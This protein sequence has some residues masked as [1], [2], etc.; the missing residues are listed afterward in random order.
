VLAVFDIKWIESDEL[1][2]ADEEELA[3]FLAASCERVV[4]AAMTAR[5]QLRDEERSR[6]L[7][8]TTRDELREA[9]NRLPTQ[10][11]Q[12]EAVQAALL[13]Y[14]TGREVP[15]GELD[16]AGLSA[17]LQV[18]RWTGESSEAKSAEIQARLEWVA[19]IE[20]L[21]RLAEGFVGRRELLAECRESLGNPDGLTERPRL[22][23]LRGQGFFIEGVGGSGK[24]SVLARLILDRRQS[25]DLSAYLSFDR[26]WLIDSGPLSIFDEVVRQVAAQLR[27]VDA[28]AEAASLRST[29]QQLSGRAKGLRD[30]ASRG[31]QSREVISPGLLEGFG[32][33]L[34]LTADQPGWRPGG[35]LVIMLDTLEE[36]AR[37]DE[38]LSAAVFD[39]LAQLQEAVPQTRV[40]GAGRALPPVV[41]SAGTVRRLTGL[42]ADD[43][44]TLLR[45]LTAGVSASEGALREIV[46]LTG[47]NP[48]SLRLAADVL[49]RTGE[50]PARM[51]AVT[52]GNVQ[53]QLYSRLL[54]HIKDPKVRAIAH[55]GLVV[56]RITPEI[57]RQVLAEPC[58]IAPLP[59][60]EADRIFRALRAEATLCEDSP[61]GDGALVHRQDVRAIMLPAIR[62]DRPAIT[63]AIHRAAVSYYTTL[64]LAGI[65]RREQLYHLLMLEAGPHDLEPLWD[66]AA[67]V[68]L[69]TVIDEFPPS[70]QV[71]LS[72]KVRG[73]R[74]DPEILVTAD[75]DEW[76]QLIRPQA[77]QWMASGQPARALDLVRQRRDADDHPLLPDV[78]IEALERLD[79]VT[80]A[81]ALAEGERKRA[82]QRGDTDLV[83]TLITAQARINERL[84]RLEKAWDLWQSLATLDRARRER[85][86]AVDDEAR[87]RELVVLTSLLRVA[88]HL[89]RSDRPVTDLRAETIALALGTPRRL[90]TDNPSLLRDL[91]AETGGESP[92]ILALADPLLLA[93]DTFQAGRDLHSSSRPAALFQAASDA[94]QEYVGRQDRLTARRRYA[95]WFI[96]RKWGVNDNPYLDDDEHLDLRNTYVPLSFRTESGTY[97][98]LVNAT[99]VLANA[100][101]G[102][103]VIY[104][105]P[106][107]GKSTLLKAYGVGV[108]E[109]SRLLER[110]R[111]PVPFLIQFRKLAQDL[112]SDIGITEYIVNEILVKDVG[113]SIDRARR[114]LKFALRHD[115][116]IVML[117]G[118]DEVTA[119]RYQAVREAVF[120]FKADHSPDFPTSQARLVL[121]CRRAHF[122]AVRNDWAPWF[123]GLECSLAPLRDA[124]IFSYL[125]KLRRNFRSPNSPERFM[126]NVRASR[127]LDLLRTPLILAIAV[128]LYA[129]R[130]YFEIP[131]SITELYRT[132]IQ[133][134]LGRHNFWLDPGAAANRFRAD[135]KYRFLREF[136]F[137]AVR[138]SGHFGYF[139]R[140][141]LVE[142]AH[143]SAPQF[144]DV[145]DPAGMVAEI[146]ERSG[147]LTEVRED[148][149]YSFANRSLQEYLVA[150][151]LRIRTDG[152]ALLLAN[153]ENLEWRQVALFYSAGQEER[154]VDTYLER[155]SRRNPELAA[156][157]LTGAAP[158]TQVAER[159]LDA[160]E[161]I[162]DDRLSALAAATRSPRVSVREMAISRLRTALTSPGGTLSMLNADIDGLLPLLNSLAGTNTAEIVALVPKVIAGLPDDPRL[163][164]PLWRCLTVPGIELL[165]ECQEIVGRLVRLAIDPEG[166]E[167]LARQ[168]PYD[169]EFLTSEVRM[170]AYPF[171]RGLPHT[172]NLVTLLAWVEYLRLTPS[173]NRYLEARA[174]GRLN[175]VEAD[176]RR[177]LS[178][179]PFWPARVASG[180]SAVAAFVIAAAT[181]ATGPRHLLQPFGWWTLVLI[182]GVAVMP[183]VITSGISVAADFYA[184]A[185]E[186]DSGNP[187]SALAASENNFISWIFGVAFAVIFPLS[188]AIAPLA[189]ATTSLP[190]YLAIA[191]GAPVIYW[192]A[193]FDIAARGS[194]YYL[195][196]PNNYVDVYDDPRS[197]L[198]LG[199]QAGE[200]ATR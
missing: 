147:L 189:L 69:A 59:A 33:L 75:N 192:L 184:P 100:S 81:L 93:Q 181:I 85:T 186:S 174:A 125:D 162:T 154:Q 41:Q 106:G 56:R 86:G 105:D 21:R 167:V 180:L 197:L 144:N 79:R 132:M 169:R 198:W 191:L 131:S 18:A 155:L 66:A 126:E 89:R 178:F 60:D 114:F 14:V 130:Q 157:C 142:F 149:V 139:T 98:K 34:A 146:I 145:P 32:Q 53:G 27:S 16:A 99:D 23:V 26:G 52:E 156:Y 175:R 138:R 73:L 83:R 80:E 84:R 65:A 122:L 96:T 68:E 165:P 177:T 151:A 120:R 28:R 160:L 112:S 136:S 47:G 95:K 74:L 48:L 103:L 44:L 141:D 102:N 110:G 35:T 29:A 127:T 161:P 50:D 116:V 153:A 166:L 190:S 1:D 121:T 82:E 115:Q 22:P 124:E 195:Y 111:R 87:V 133:E 176:R 159:V 172:H 200:A 143:L 36:L 10:G 46:R 42:D 64:P 62:Q 164:E 39:F 5:W 88:R 38:A 196:R 78:E 92:E 19:V 170:R 109:K 117:D 97:D 129:R 70:G 91:A 49:S 158:S 128:G 31:S 179:S 118:L 199:I 137:D 72:S 104:G 17:E 107:S 63:R 25:A 193:R 150:E 134:M 12:R 20:P 168:D 76:C 7:R 194:R 173:G 185:D 101:A 3:E 30:I 183:F 43:A 58:G 4:D 135:D 15:V 123:E 108:L 13:R 61:E 148:G 71:Y 94:A 163:V 54:E 45:R 2:D 90:L 113:L 140:A 187:F 152:N 182:I 51:I 40:V 11:D 24:S 37:R 9:W 77:L 57:I 171:M 67:G 6:V 119:D 8:T 55:P 188:F